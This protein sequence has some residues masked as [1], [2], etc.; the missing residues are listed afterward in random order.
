MA[1]Q[2][3]TWIGQWNL[4]FL[5]GTMVMNLKEDP[6]TGAL[7]GTVQLIGN[8]TFAGIF[9]I[10]GEGSPT[11]V[12]LSGQDP[13]LSY[14]IT[15]SAPLPTPTTMEGYYDIYKIPNSTPQE[16]GTFSLELIST[17]II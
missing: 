8:G 10:Y 5:F 11:F 16:S 17:V 12:L 7:S 2:A 4:G 6:L 15:I 14:A 13:T 1:E 9:N 3:G